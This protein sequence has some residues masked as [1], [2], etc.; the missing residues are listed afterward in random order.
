[1]KSFRHR[2]TFKNSNAMGI[3][4][5]NSCFGL[6]IEHL[7]SINFAKKVIAAM[8]LNINTGTHIGTLLDQVQLRNGTVSLSVLFRIQKIIYILLLINIVV[9]P[10]YRCG[11]VSISW[12]CC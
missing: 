10:M 9:V 5:A 12:Y 6:H 7:I 4:D 8:G 11:I 3:F 1:M 2:K